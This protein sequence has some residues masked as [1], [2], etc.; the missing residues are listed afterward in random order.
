MNPSFK[1]MVPIFGAM[2]KLRLILV[3]A[4]ARGIG[5][6][7]VEEC[8]RFARASGYNENMLWTESVPIEPATIFELILNLT[9]AKGPGL[10]KKRL[11]VR[12]RARYF[13]CDEITGASG[14]FDRRAADSRHVMGD[15]GVFDCTGDRGVGARTVAGHV[16]EGLVARR[17]RN[18]D[19]GIGGG[20]RCNVCHNVLLVCR[21]SIGKIVIALCMAE[22]W[23]LGALRLAPEH[24]P[25][26][27]LRIA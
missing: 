24:M 11:R 18:G 27:D 10:D 3:V 23:R 13:D 2:G 6:A 21:G 22:H 1:P 25:T 7:L 8:I 19:F 12:L 9:T 14:I 26:P 4:K 5:P 20:I 15:G 16:K 17:Q